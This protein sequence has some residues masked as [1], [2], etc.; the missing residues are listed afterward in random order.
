MY[1]ETLYV[2]VP[3]YQGQNRVGLLAAVL[4]FDRIA[5]LMRSDTNNSSETDTSSDTYLVDEQ[6]RPLTHLRDTS[7]ALSHS[8][9]APVFSTEAVRMASKGL[10][11]L[12]QYDGHDGERRIGAYAPL[13]I[14]DLGVG[15]Q[16]AI[17]SEEYRSAV[18]APARKSLRIA[19]AVAGISAGLLVCY[20]TL[21]AMRRSVTQPVD[22]LLFALEDLHAGEGDL[23]RRLRKTSNDEIGQMADAF[24]QFLDK[25]HGVIGEVI[26]SI[27]R[28][29]VAAGQIRATASEVNQVATEQ[30]SS[31]EETSAALEEMSVTISQNAE[32][33]RSTE[34]I[35][36]N[37]AVTARNSADVVKEAVS[38]MQ[39]I[40]LKISIIDEIAQKTNLLA[41]NAEIEAAR[42]GEHGRGFSVVA[43]EIRKLATQSK[44]AAADV[45]QLAGNTSNSATNAGDML[46]V[47][48]PEVIK[49]AELVREIA[50]ASDEQTGGV[51]QINMA[52]SQIETATRDGLANAEELSRA[53]QNI[54]EQVDQLQHSIAFFKV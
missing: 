33:A 13:A 29:S 4:P 39:K 18:L 34:Q 26:Q 53:A 6:G 11:G 49:T 22:D 48:V 27:E 45:G 46:D 24:N 19:N 25:V 47:V 36:A 1:A 14:A 17:I 37:A 30:A 3:V 21:L 7:G 2:V 10:T 41:L 15:Q 54:H 52:V 12:A 5:R 32:N 31:V 23:T 42:A 43:N 16:W 50:N 38:E 20:V 40:A 35:A 8:E 44:E 51:E 28:L 9:T